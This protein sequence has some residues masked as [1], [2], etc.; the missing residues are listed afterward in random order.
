MPDDDGSQGGDAS[1]GRHC[2]IAGAGIGGLAA[3]LFLA[4]V[5]WRV[6][7]AEREPLLGEV[8]AGLQLSP[9][10]TRLLREIGI[11]GDLDGIAVAPHRLRIW[12]ATSGRMLNHALLGAKAAREFGAPFLVVHRADLQNA[13]TRRAE[14]HPAITLLTGHR[15]QDIREHADGITGIFETETGEIRLDADLLVGAD[16]IWSR[17]RSLCG[18]PAPTHYSGKTAWRALIP[19]EQAPLFA[20]EADV[21]LWMGTRAH[22]VHYPVCGGRDINVVAII[23]DA[24]R[25]EG[26]SAPGDPDLLAARFS[27]WAKPARDLIAA[28]EG[29]KRWALCDRAPESRWSRARMTLLGDAAHPM[30]PFLAQGAG[31]AIEDGA[32]LAALLAPE[33]S[34]PAALRR[35]D[36]KRIPRTARI[37]KEARRQARI[38]HL[39]GFAAR[40]RDSTIALLPGDMILSRYCWIF[41]ADARE[42]D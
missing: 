42:T 6:T 1:D 26:W 41:D 39:G 15:L 37:Q 34:I 18:L 16:G 11:L 10:A 13:L 12:S 33:T 20:R 29:W 22:L 27:D 4:K 7:L 31:Q 21:N 3:A 19:R 30:M 9:N 23:E 14:A 24:W 17:A 36:L 28:A 25:E 32:A 2:L 35:Y 8:G 5:G 38:Y 40:L